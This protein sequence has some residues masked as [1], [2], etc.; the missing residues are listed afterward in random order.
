MR[1]QIGSVLRTQNGPAKLQILSF[2]NGRVRI[3]APFLV[4]NTDQVWVRIFDIGPPFWRTTPNLA[5]ATAVWQWFNHAEHLAASKGLTILR[6][7]LDETAVCLFPGSTSGAIFVSPKRMREECVQKVAKWKRRCCLTHI[8]L[9]C[10]QADIQPQLPQFVIGNERTLLARNMQSLRRVCPPNV[11]LVRQK[12]AWSSAALTARIVRELSAALRRLGARSRNLQP[13]LV[14]DAAKIHFAPVVLNACRAVGIWV[15]IVPARTTWLLQPLDTHAFSQ[16][17][18]ELRRAYQRARTASASANGDLQ[19]NEFL[20]CVYHAIRTVLQGRQW[21][22]A[23]DQN[24]LGA[25]QA[26]LSEKVLQR[27]SLR[28]RVGI[29]AER[30]SPEQ[31]RLCLP[32]RAHIEM[33]L[34]WG[35]YDGMGKERLRLRRLAGATID[36]A[37]TA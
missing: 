24:G 8:G 26:A 32:R 5:E 15:V 33:A 14:M 17:K 36:A 25:M 34:L 11:I 18:S 22:A 2:Y 23:F 12:S 13:V 19:I 7:N 20:Q 21:A 37:D 28:G 31:V 16:Y 1:T 9:I 4:R 6:V 30:P 3:T 10:D 29:S 27:L 35:A